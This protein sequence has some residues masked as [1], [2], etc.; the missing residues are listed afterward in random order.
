MG[1]EILSGI[2]NSRKTCGTF[3]RMFFFLAARKDEYGHPSTHKQ[4]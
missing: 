2:N 4:S 1:I 3:L